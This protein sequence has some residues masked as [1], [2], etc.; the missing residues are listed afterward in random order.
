MFRKAMIVMLPI[1][2]IAATGCA[3]RYVW[4][5]EPNVI[6]RSNS[7]FEARISPIF[8]VDGYKGFVLTVHNK[9]SKEIKIDWEKTQ[10]LQNEKA[11]GGF[12]FAEMREGG[13]KKEFE[14]IASYSTVSKEIFPGSLGYYSAIAKSTVYNPM[15]P[16]EN[17]VLLVVRVNGTEVEERLNLKILQEKEK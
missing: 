1:L 11:S 10:Y 4:K 16:G 15:P 2:F 3:P 6:E 7:T 9:T 14:S 5:T 13:M 12:L 17:G 8:I